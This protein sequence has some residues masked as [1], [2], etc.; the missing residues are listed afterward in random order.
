[1]K[2]A[3][4]FATTSALV[5]C[6]TSMFVI[7]ACASDDAGNDVETPRE[8]AGMPSPEPAS[9]AGAEAGAEA[10]DTGPCADCEHFSDTC[11]GETVCVQEGID[12]SYRIHV[13]RG[14]SANDVWAG[15]ANGTLLH[16]DGTAWKP[17]DA[18]TAETIVSLWLRQSTEV[19]LVSL[20]SIHT[21]GLPFPDAG[22]PSPGG[23]TAHGAPP[24]PSYSSAIQLQ[25]AWAPPGADWLWCASLDQYALFL[26]AFARG[27]WRMRVSP[28]TGGLEV[29][30]AVP[31]GTCQNFPCGSMTNIHG[32]SPDTA[33]AVGLEGATFRIT[34]AQGAAPGI[35]IFDSRT[36]SALYGVWAASENDAWSVG[37]A[38]TVRRYTGDARSWE[39][40][41][42]PTTETLRAVW[43][44]GPNDVWAV[45]DRAVVLHYDGNTWTRVKVA[46]VGKLRPD[47][48]TV[49]TTSPGHVWIGGDGVLLSLGGKP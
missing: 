45:G 46:G 42:V 47:L 1:M 27:L 28:V 26:P 30:D 21:R 9:E 19:A 38:G 10:P 37:G 39:I 14:R 48:Y 6:A 40:V 24:G 7:A 33:W 36:W 29:A 44:S 12:S 16:F 43:G 17:S 20:R 41:D 32:A 3:S 49:W 11:T 13:I 18:A 22:A 25:G 34:D 5:A 2:K 8:D 35:E 15:G 31:L 23:W 4:I